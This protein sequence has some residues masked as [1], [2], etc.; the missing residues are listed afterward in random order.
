MVK[1][2]AVIS[3]LSVSDF[4]PQYGVAPNSE[5]LFRIEAQLGDECYGVLRRYAKDCHS[6]AL[7]FA[8]ER[9]GVVIT[10]LSQRGFNSG[11]IDWEV[12]LSKR[13]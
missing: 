9:E 2:Y 12:S 5:G 3:R 11:D 10:V 8:K 13:A 1:W 6:E 7:A 4:N